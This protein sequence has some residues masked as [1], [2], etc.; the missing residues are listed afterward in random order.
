MKNKS[1]M[2]KRIVLSLVTLC[3]IA[4]IFINSSFDADTSD[5]HSLGVTDILNNFLHSLNINI[6]LSNHFV[7][8]CAHFT[9]Y[10]VLGVLLFYTVKAYISKIDYKVLIAPACGLSVAA[11]DETIQLFSYGRSG[12]ISDVLLDFSGTCTAVLILFFISRMRKS[13]KD[14]EVLNGSD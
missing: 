6:T 5:S 12:Q 13:K 14:K 8:K 4:Y 1:L 2:C 9:E 7:R 3:L 11:I 10:F